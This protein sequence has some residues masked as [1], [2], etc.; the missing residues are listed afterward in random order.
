MFALDEFGGLPHDEPGR[1]RL[2]LQRLLLSEVDLAADHF[3]WLDAD[4]PDSHAVCARYDAAIGDGFDLVILGIGTNGHLGMNEPGSPADSPT[5]RVDLDESTVQASARSF[6]SIDR[7]KLPRWGLTVGLG[8]ILASREVWVLATGAGKADIVRRTISG[9][10]TTDIP[11][12]LLQGHPRC[13][14][15]V[16]DLHVA[17]DEPVESRGVGS[18]S[19]ASGAPRGSCRT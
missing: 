9:A 15:F 16:E 17:I 11:A 4:A 8:P 3:H 14:V 19:A 10:I 5:R 2:T 13:S 18:Q 7:D 12:S 6:P 1:T